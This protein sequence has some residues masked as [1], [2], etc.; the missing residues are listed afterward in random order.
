MI[1]STPPIGLRVHPLTEHF[2]MLDILAS[3]N[4]LQQITLERFFQVI[5]KESEE[6][7][8][9]TSAADRRSLDSVFRYG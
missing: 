1:S 7:I 8:R 5:S 4:L 9:S 6:F 2:A 3:R